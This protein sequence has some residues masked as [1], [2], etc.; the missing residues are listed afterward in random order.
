[1]QSV[2]LKNQAGFRKV[3]GTVL[4]NQQTGEVVYTPPQEYD[5]IVAAMNN[6]VSYINDDSLSDTDPLVK[7]AVIHFTSIPPAYGN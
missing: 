6:L 5:T 1:M 2:F 4:K 7:M 3:P